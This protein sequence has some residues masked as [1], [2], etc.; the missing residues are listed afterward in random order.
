MCQVLSLIGIKSTTSSPHHHSSPSL[1]LLHVIAHH[2]HPSSHIITCPTPR[3]MLE[4]TAGRQPSLLKKEWVLDCGEGG[5]R[6]E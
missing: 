4:K 1:S 2:H 3:G 5:V 6:V